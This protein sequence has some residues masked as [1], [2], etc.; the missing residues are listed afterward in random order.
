MVENQR[1]DIA[2][3]EHLK[4]D[5]SSITMYINA[6]QDKQLVCHCTFSIMQFSSKDQWY[7]R[8]M[9]ELHFRNQLVYLVY[10]FKNQFA[11]HATDLKVETLA[12]VALYIVGDEFSRTI[13]P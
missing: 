1:K 3:Q 10:Q 11:G 9:L 7:Y 12:L 6:L 4:N 13:C 8:S 2:E 5:L